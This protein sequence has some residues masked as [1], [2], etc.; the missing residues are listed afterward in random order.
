MADC[1]G[2]RCSPPACSCLGLGVAAVAPAASPPLGQPAHQRRLR[3][4][5]HVRLDLLGGRHRGDL[6]GLPRLG[7]RAGGN[8]DR[9]RLRALQPGRQRPAVLLLLAERLGRGR[10]RLPRRQRHR[11]H[12]HQ[13]LDAV[14]GELDRAVDQLHHRL[15]HHQRD[16]LRQR[17]VRAAGVLRRRPVAD[18]RRPGGGGGGGGTTAPAAPASL[19]VTGDHVVV[20][21]AVLGG[22]IGH[23][24]R[25]LRVGGRQPGG[26]RHRHHR[27]RHRAGRLDRVHVHRQRLQ[28]GWPVAGVEFG[29]RDHV[30][31][32]S[33]G[34]AAVAA[35]RRAARA[36]PDG[37]LAGLR[38]R[39]HPAH[40]GVR[41]DQLQ[42]GRGGVRRRDRHPRPGRVQPRPDAGVGSRR[43][44]ASS[45]SS[46]TSRRCRP[47]ARRSSSRSA[48]RT[49]RSRVNDA[50]SATAFAS[51]VDSLIQQYGF[52]GVDIDLENGV[53]PTYMASALEQLATDVGS[54][55]IIT[56]APQTV[57]TQCT[58]NDYFHWRWTSSRS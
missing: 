57:D 16:D 6:A 5:Q 23:R 50:A 58:G 52:N 18:R 40:P 1:D 10:L 44:H 48:A 46:T 20:G 31:S 45:S 7:L 8:A 37:L 56:L 41:A 22:A 15:G 26:D 35:V 9:Q 36:P 38:Q 19:A 27:H 4:R 34:G 28:L 3:R 39:R 53:N 13:R 54:S 17:V 2:C 51:S 30:G 55:L 25:L 14:R 32:S 12:R 42:P 33:G 43:V 49:A 29:Q 21:L 24:H 11:R 47:G